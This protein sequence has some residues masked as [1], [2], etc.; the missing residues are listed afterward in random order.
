MSSWLNFIKLSFFT[1][2]KHSIFKKF[3][4]LFFWKNS[5]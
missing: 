2:R 5:V 1:P 4:F 3:I